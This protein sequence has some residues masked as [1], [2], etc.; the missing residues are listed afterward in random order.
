MVPENNHV[1]TDLWWIKWH[2]DKI[3]ICLYSLLVK[4]EILI[5]AA[6][7]YQ[8]SAQCKTPCYIVRKLRHSFVCY[9]PIFLGAASLLG[10]P[11]PVDED[12]KMLRNVDNYSP[13]K[14]ANIAFVLH[15]YHYHHENAKSCVFPTIY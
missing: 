1:I 9:I 4:L 2:T 11:H 10:L 12:S 8:S 14:T 7:K 3:I 5:R 13:V 6:S 15:L